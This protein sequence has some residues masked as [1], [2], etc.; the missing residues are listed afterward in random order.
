VTSNES[1]RRFKGLE[2]DV[3]ILV[4][5]PEDGERLNELLYVG[6]TR[7]TTELVVI[8]PPGLAARMR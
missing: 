5:L 1:N 8:A 7:A 3:I 2:R 6:M 4:E